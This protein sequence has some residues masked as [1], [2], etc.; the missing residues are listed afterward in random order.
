MHCLFVPVIVLQYTY[1]EQQSCMY[2]LYSTKSKVCES[3]I[4]SPSHHKINIEQEN[5]R[6]ACPGQY[7]IGVPLV[8]TNLVMVDHNDGIAGPLI[9]MVYYSSDVIDN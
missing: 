4:I 9:I 8:M 2:G 1:R 5:I 7:G 3:C 6:S